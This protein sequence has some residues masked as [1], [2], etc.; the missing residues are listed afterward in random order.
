MGS[1]LR[2]EDSGFVV[3]GFGIRVDSGASR[4]QLHE[5]WVY[6]GVSFPQVLNAL[7]NLYTEI[8]P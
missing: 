5:N 8:H 2:L 7:A 3:S 4:G 6:T 1:G